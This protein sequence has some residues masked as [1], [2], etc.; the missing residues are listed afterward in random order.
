[1]FVTSLAASLVPD[2]IPSGV[3]YTMTC[4]LQQIIKN[5]NCHQK[6]I[7]EDLLALE[8]KLDFT[9]RAQLKKTRILQ[10]L[11]LSDI[12]LLSYTD[13]NNQK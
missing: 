13:E 6:K 11:I 2:F 4:T 5:L 3:L 1:L 7:I 8:R 10:C 12:L 9:D